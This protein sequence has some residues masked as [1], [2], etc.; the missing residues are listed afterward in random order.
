MFV[1]SLCK[2]YVCL[3]SM[4]SCFLIPLALATTIFTTQLGLAQRIPELFQEGYAARE[5]MSFLASELIFRR[6]IELNPQNANGYVGLGT[7]FYE[8]RNLGEAIANFRTSLQ[9]NPDQI[10]A[11]NRLRTITE[12][13]LREAERC[14]VD[15][16][17]RTP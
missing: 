7:V 12:N 15:Y 3:K 16:G 11:Q 6:K 1:S 2:K 13:N 9:L 8:Q 5:G 4:R 14:L 17:S 10:P